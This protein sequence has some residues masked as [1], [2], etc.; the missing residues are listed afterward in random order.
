MPTLTRAQVPASILRGCGPRGWA[1]D[2]TLLSSPPCCV[3]APALKVPVPHSPL[4]PL[5]CLA[6]SYSSFKANSN[7][8]LPFSEKLF[9][10]K[11]HEALPGLPWLFF[12]FF[13]NFLSQGFT[14]CIRL[15]LSPL[16]S[17]AW[18]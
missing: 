5:Q 8:V 9:I 7:I 15:P 3:P 18:P 6:G 2:G 10:L 4:Y 13:F 12:L 14:M 1:W 17:L 16:W 11:Q